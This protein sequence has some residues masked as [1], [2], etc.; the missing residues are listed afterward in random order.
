MHLDILY[1]CTYLDGNFFGNCLKVWDDTCLLL[2]F[3][4]DTRRQLCLDYDALFLLLGGMLAPG[5][6]V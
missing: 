6:N 1:A 4:V 2:I 5:S 3:L